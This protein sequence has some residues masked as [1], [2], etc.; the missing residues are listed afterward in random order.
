MSCYIQYWIN[1]YTTSIGLGVFHSGVE[2]YGTGMYYIFEKK[3]VCTITKKQKFDNIRYIRYISAVEY[4][5]GGHAQ[6]KSGIFEITPRVADEL[7]EQ[8]RYR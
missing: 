8:F 3:R 5:Y 4:A 7:G 6:P 2:I 1:E